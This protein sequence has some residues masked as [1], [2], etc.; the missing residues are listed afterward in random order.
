MK[1][2]FQLFKSRHPLVLSIGQIE[3]K[4]CLVQSEIWVLESIGTVLKPDVWIL[5][6]LFKT[7]LSRTWIASVENK[8]EVHTTLLP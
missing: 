4:T 6:F 2:A 8:A 7:R 5:C 1:K 3:P